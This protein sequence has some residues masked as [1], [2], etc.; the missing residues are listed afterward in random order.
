MISEHY[1]ISSQK[2]NIN[3]SCSL[4]KCLLVSLFE[5]EVKSHIAFDITIFWDKFLK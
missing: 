5:A 2:S 1:P 3:L 4:T